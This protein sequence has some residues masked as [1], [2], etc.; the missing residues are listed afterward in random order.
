[1]ATILVVDDERDIRALLTTL[2]SNAG[3]DVLEAA[4]G[5]AAMRMACQERPDVILLDVLMPPVGGLEVLNRLRNNP[6]TRSIQVILV[7]ALPG[8]KI[9]DETKEGIGD[10]FFIVKPWSRGAIERVVKRALAC[11]RGRR[12]C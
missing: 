2:L 9:E 10:T 5:M 7:T 4:N 8:M 6:A 1:M 12:I 11:K 3:Y